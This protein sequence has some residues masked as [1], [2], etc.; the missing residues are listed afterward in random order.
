MPQRLNLPFG[1]C[2]KIESLNIFHN[3]IEIM[4]L[5]DNR[6]KSLTKIYYPEALLKK[7][8]N[9]YSEHDL[10]I[11]YKQIAFF[12]GLKYL[13]VFPDSYD[14]SLI[15]NGLNKSTLE[16]FQ[17][18]ALKGWSQ[19][20]YENKVTS[21]DGPQIIGDIPAKAYNLPFRSFQSTE[22]LLCANGGGKDSFLMMKM[23]EQAHIPYS[24][25]QHARSEYGCF[26]LQHSIQARIFKHLKTINRAHEISILD[27]F[28]DGLMAHSYNKNIVGE[29]INGHPCQVGWPEMIFEA[30]PF[31]LNYGYSGFVTGNEA[32][33]D[34]PQAVWLSK[35]NIP[36]NHQWIKS[37]EA[38]ILLNTY[39][40]E[41][42]LSGFKSFSLIKP[43]YDY[44]IYHNLAAYPEILSSIHSCNI[45]KPWCKKCS[46][47]A[48]V[49][50]NLVAVYGLEHVKK[51]FQTNLFDDEDLTSHWYDLLGVT[52]HNAFEC[53]GEIGETRLAFYQCLE[54]GYTG[55]AISIFQS[56]FLDPN[57]KLF[58]SQPQEY[59]LSLASRYNA[60]NKNHI[61]P[62]EIYQKI[63]PF[64]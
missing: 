13:L 51:I 59:W 7:L 27:D 52:R 64:L 2:V 19:H 22:E 30:L 33:A 25:F 63:K 53:V 12:E 57:S 40:N 17:I 45:S 48:Y 14:V 61:I 41:C 44:R 47:C 1:R 50:L 34:A 58:V 49:Y 46:K 6:Y 54:K 28:T 18:I 43:L 37:N 21:Y 60:I 39:I 8:S 4:Y 36:I 56:L 38:S 10:S 23:L 35:K 24:V 26:D 9:K 3:H 15:A 29:C 16:L 42:L 55:K 62:A 5:L 31:V 32:S 11:L 20:N